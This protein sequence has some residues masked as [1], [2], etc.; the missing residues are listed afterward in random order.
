MTSV[1]RFLMILSALRHNG[2]RIMVVYNSTYILMGQMKFITSNPWNSRTLLKCDRIKKW[3]WRLLKF[4][5]DSL[6][7]PSLVEYKKGYLG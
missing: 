7:T 1:L 4:S 3:G 2:S 6:E 5:Q